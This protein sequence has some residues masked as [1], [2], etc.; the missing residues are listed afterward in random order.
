MK[1][2]SVPF[3]GTVHSFGIF[4][5]LKSACCTKCAGQFLYWFHFLCTVRFRLDFEGN[6][7]AE[8]SGMLVVVT[9][10]MDSL[11]S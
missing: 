10:M 8:E 5:D 3:G 9:G 6:C 4:R 1:K 7:A 11:G 2:E